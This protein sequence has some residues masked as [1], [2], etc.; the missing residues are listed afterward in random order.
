MSFFNKRRLFILLIG[1]IIVVALI[2]YSLNDRENLS[3]P[4][5]FIKDTIGLAQNI[6]HKPIQYATDVVGNI[7][8]LKNTYDENR[9]LREKLAEYKSLIYEVQDLKDDNQELQATLDKTDE[10]IGDFNPIQSSV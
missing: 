3:T 5:Q 7:K 8:D 9:V 4:E 6:I 1:I 2:G 10:S